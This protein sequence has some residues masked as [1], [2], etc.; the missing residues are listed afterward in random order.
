MSLELIT[1]Q[2]LHQ[3]KAE[4]LL[5]IKALAAAKGESKKW[6]KTNE[7]KKL[8]RISPG[9]LQTLRINGTLLYSRI[10]NTIYYDADHIA[11]LLEKN[12]VTPAG[13]F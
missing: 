1:K 2:D 10:G 8:L 11:G 6:L 7:V 9:T 12:K 3:F 5:E 13:R 4:L